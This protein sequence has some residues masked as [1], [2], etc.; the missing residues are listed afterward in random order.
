MHT[1]KRTRT[2]IIFFHFAVHDTTDGG[3]RQ[4]VV[5]EA[6]LGR[7][8]HARTAEQIVAA[9]RS[10]SVL[11]HPGPTLC[12]ALDAHERNPVVGWT[13]RRREYFVGVRRAFIAVAVSARAQGAAGATA[14]GVVTK[15][16]R[17]RCCVRSDMADDF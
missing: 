10:R 17:T 1:T 2:T 14:V 4:R 8:V 6:A 7:G 12:R 16:C 3:V 13:R 11:V 9:T 15:G 5:L